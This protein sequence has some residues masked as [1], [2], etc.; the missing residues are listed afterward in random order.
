M[1]YPRRSTAVARRRPVRKNTR[2]TSRNYAKTITD[3]ASRAAS[4]RVPYVSLQPR[5]ELVKFR[6]AINAGLGHTIE[7][8]SG[9]VVDYVYRA[10]SCYDPYAGAGGAQPR[11]FD[12]LMTRFR[13]GVVVKSK[14]D[15]RFFYNEVA[16]YSMR[17]GIQLKDTTTALG[18]AAHQDI[19][20]FPR[21]VM[22]ILS[23]T[24]GG[25]KRLRY[26]YTPRSFFSMKNV[27]DE[28]DMWF[29]SAADASESASFHVFGY[30]LDSQTQE[31]F[32]TGFIDYTVMMLHPV[33]SSAS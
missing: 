26:N 3:T 15:I 2:R 18:V 19:A 7:S 32:V 22:T 8:A 1:P 13:H 10:N 17:V 20:E 25:V 21:T 14:I 23:P 5:A 33:L 9:A 16:V 4:G 6:F 31:C 30:G 24:G 11:G 12:Q 27:Q 28:E 29:T